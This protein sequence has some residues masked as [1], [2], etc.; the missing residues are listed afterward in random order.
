MILQGRQHCILEQAYFSSDKYSTKSDEELVSL[1]QNDA[2][3]LNEII[4]RYRNLAKA[5]SRTYFLA[6]A[7]AEDIV[8]EGMIGLFRA[9]KDFDPD[10]NVRFSAFAELCVTRQI[11]SAVKMASRNKHKPLNTYVSLSESPGDGGAQDLSYAAVLISDPEELLIAKEQEAAV[12]KYLD[13]ALTKFEQLVMNSYL[14]GRSYKEISEMS[15]K[16]VKA[17]DNALQRIKKK[18]KKLTLK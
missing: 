5:K 7:D 18:L 16:S 17:V 6:G 15:G 4:C 9:V 13:G 10:K 8:Q 14:A 11:I 1:A 3:A 2:D 12:K